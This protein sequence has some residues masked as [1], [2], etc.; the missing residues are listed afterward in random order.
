MLSE[1]DAEMRELAGEELAELKESVVAL[2]AQLE[3]LLIPKDPADDA[4]I[5][6]EIR[7]GTGGDEAGIFVGDPVAHVSSLCR[8]TRLASRNHECQ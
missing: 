3:A 1:G 7:A 6:L 2:E 8:T 4:N 5:F